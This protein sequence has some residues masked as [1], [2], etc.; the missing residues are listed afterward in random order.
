M[1]PEIPKRSY[2]TVANYPFLFRLLHWV[3]GVSA[4]I[5]T[6]TGLSQHASSAPDWSLFSGVLPPFFWP[7]RV[8]LWHC[9]ASL[10][11]TP[12][13]LA[14]LWLYWK[15]RIHFRLVHLVLLGSGLLLVLSGL[16]T[17]IWPGTPEL[18]LISRWIHAVAGIAL[19]PIGFIWHTVEGLTRYLRGLVTVFCIWRRPQWLQL[20]FFLPL[21]LFT[22]CLILNG[23][24]FPPPW[25]DLTAKR[26]SESQVKTEELNSLPWE[27]AN[28]LRIVLTGG[29]HFGNGWTEVTLRALHDG[30]EIFVL[31]EWLDAT[32]DRQYMPWEKTSDGWKQLV[33]N[34]DDES[35]YYE[36][37]FSLIFPAEPDWRFQKFGCTLYCHVGG[38]RFY[39]YKGSSRIVDVW[40][41]KATRTDPTGQV[42]D[43]YWWEVDFS[44]KDVGR[45]GD[46]KERGGYQKNDSEYKEH[47]AF[48]PDGP[49]AVRQ[50]IIFTDRAI[51][52]TPEAAAKIPAGT[53]I[54][55]IVASPAVGDRGDIA[56]MSRHED[57]R[58]KLYLRRKLE[59]GSKYDVRFLP[60][61]AHP[62]GCAAFER[63]SKRHAYE[64]P[65]YRL[66]LEE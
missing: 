38:G 65:V 12:A 36:D 51:P 5:L 20:F 11:F 62:F 30:Q 28:L 66:V 25:R 61:R 33:T 34:P 15:K 60:G 64:F 59:T 18:Y 4:V 23:F 9:L 57:G 45:H 16:V 41:W 19:L 27:T 21:V 52:Y 58:W 26:I 22:S 10:A 7:G 8:H 13:L 39:G 42:D 14:I 54:P 40:H 47:P 55:G 37:K 63:S 53:K 48:L 24:P 3:L 6:L 50:G 44:A 49:S 35:T 43:K 2:P 17:S 32:E 29:I 31:A 46:P 56:C 1:L